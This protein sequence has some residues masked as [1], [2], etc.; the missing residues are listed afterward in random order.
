MTYAGV[1]VKGE[2]MKDIRLRQGMSLRDVCRL[3]EEQKIKTIDP[4][5]LSSYERGYV[6]PRPRTLLAIATALGVTV[7]DLRDKAREAAAREAAALAKARE[8]AA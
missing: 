7:D 2:V 4:R 5:N 1:P 6:Q 8:A 3:A